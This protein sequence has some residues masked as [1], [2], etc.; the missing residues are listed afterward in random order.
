M[1]QICSFT[2]SYWTLRQSW[3]SYRLQLRC[4][5]DFEISEMPLLVL[6]T[7]ST[8]TS[9]WAS[10]SVRGSSLNGVRVPVLAELSQNLTAEAPAILRDLQHS[11]LISKIPGTYPRC[12][13]YVA[14]A[15]TC[16]ELNATQATS[17]RA[18]ESWRT[19]S[20]L[21]LRYDS[22]CCHYH[23]TA[24]ALQAFTS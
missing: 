16:D 8:A 23:S 2:R 11:M 14:G 3:H 19:Y 12:L 6:R 18:S 1:R 4:G 10:A 5:V 24:F 17:D 22:N 7:H 20:E 15:G 13:P 21:L 9:S